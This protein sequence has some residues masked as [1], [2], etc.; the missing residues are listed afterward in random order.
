MGLVNWWTLNETLNDC[1]NGN[2][3]VAGSGFNSNGAGKIGN[4]YYASTTSAYAQSANTIMI[5]GSM[6]ICCWFKQSS[7]SKNPN[8]LVTL[9][10][11]SD[12]SNIGLNLRN[13][14]LSV[15]IGY[16][17]GTREYDVRYG[18]TSIAVNTWYHAALTFDKTSNRITLYLNGVKEYT[19]VLTKTVKHAAKK[20]TVNR[21]SVDYTYDYIS[22]CYYNDIRL[23]NH[24]LSYKEVKEIAKAKMIHY[25]CNP[26]ATAGKYRD[27][28][29]Y[30]Y[31]AIATNHPTFSRDDSAMG[32]A[33]YLFVNGSKQSNGE[34]QYFKSENT[35]R[36]PESGTLSYYL[37][38]SGT[39]NTDNKYAVGFSQF[40]SINGL[41]ASSSDNPSVGMIYYQDASSY[42]TKV[43]TSTII[44]DGNW[45]MYTL[46]WTVNG[47]LKIYVD[48][49]LIGSHTIEAMAHAG[50]FRSFIVGSAW[51]AAYGG[52]SGYI[53]DVRLYATQ[54][55]DADVLELYQTKASV[56]KNGKM[57][58]NEICELDLSSMTTKNAYD[59]NWVRIFYHNNKSG[60]VLFSS[61]KNEFL[62]CNT[63]DKKSELWALERF[64]DKDGK[65]ELLLEYG[66]ETGYN[67]WKQTSDF[68][69]TTAITGY[70]AVAC[71]WT[72]NAWGGLALSQDAGSTWVDGSPNS[73]SSSWWYAIGCKGAF[74]GGIPGGTKAVTGTLS[75]WVRTDNVSSVKVTKKGIVYATEIC[76]V[77]NTSMK[78]KTE[79]SANW[80]RLFYHNSNAG[81][82]LFSTKNEFLKCNETNKISD[83]W[84]LE[85]FRGKDGKFELLLQ[86]QNSTGYNRWKQTSNFTKT[87]AIEGYEAVQCSWTSQNWGGLALSSTT[88]TWVD[89][90]PG[91]GTW[92]YAIGARVAYSGGMP[93]AADPAETGWVEVWVR[94]DDINL[95]RMIKGGKCKAT[96][97]IEN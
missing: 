29:G 13:D 71:S 61:D 52:Y 32:T 38:Q 67:R 39:R 33:S 8:A 72:S 14:K 6:S 68:T 84:A 16:T 12:T 70:E 95:F 66:D 60:T 73:G 41:D 92:Y 15:S 51:D 9:H 5:D 27:S 65:F 2:A 50:T 22:P 24:E 36:V 59:A 96:E 75:L 21:W 87:T 57:F 17:D 40:S 7:V 48:G 81:T 86:Y 94:C 80:V 26:S 76:E 77:D 37:K 58:A 35:I 3:L 78:T 4:C 63:A 53:D 56:S 91:A 43:S 44:R 47:T 28:S 49:S 18:T 31:H 45:H 83:L 97:F 54:L 89:G 46:S 25:T 20:L 62:R 30:K 88:N 19:G 82:V 11:H 64:R 55:S 42:T 1:K 34:Y 74:Q 23:Y 85:Q 90:S 93:D 79:L 69:K 10:D